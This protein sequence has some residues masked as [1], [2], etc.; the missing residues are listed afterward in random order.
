MKEKR[1]KMKEKEAGIGLYF[2]KIRYLLKIGRIVSVISL[3]LGRQGC[4]VV[5]VSVFY[6]DGLFS[7]PAE[8]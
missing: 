2:K 6:F 8:V 3:S 4:R 1:T 7:K 5:S